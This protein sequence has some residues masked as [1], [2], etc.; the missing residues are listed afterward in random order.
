MDSGPETSSARAG[1]WSCWKL[2]ALALVA[3]A[4]SLFLCPGPAQAQRPLGIDVSHWQGTITWSSVK[5]SGIAFAFCKATD[6]TS[7]TDPTFTANIVNAKAACVYI[8]PYH[9]AHP[10]SDT[11]QAEAAW[12][13]SVAS[14]Y[15]KGDGKTL[16]P[17]LD[18]E[19]GA[20]SGHVGASSLSDWVNQWC[21][22]VSNSAAAAGP[23]VKPGI[24]ISACNAS[25]LNSSV[26][27]WTPWIADWNG[28][29]PQTSTP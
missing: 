29:D 17:M 22:A 23:T 1:A 19:G 16:P 2:G 12:F 18:L 5:N 4:S 6:N 26:A 7:Y 13:W 10:E 8:G 28:Q 9:F 11:P 27:Q 15:I 14:P 21:N 3:T 24:Y 20:F 25:Y